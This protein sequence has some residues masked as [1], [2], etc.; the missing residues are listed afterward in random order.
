[1]QHDAAP[2]QG[3]A[4]VPGTYLREAQLLTLLPLSHATIWRGVKAGTFPAPI[5]MGARLTVWEADAVLAWI[6]ERKTASAAGR[7]QVAA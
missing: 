3:S 5:K 6:D 2:A 1:M 7:N 4:L